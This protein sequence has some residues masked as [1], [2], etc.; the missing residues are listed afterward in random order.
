MHH[1]V[2]I[3]DAEVIIIIAINQD[4]QAPIF[5]LCDVGLVGDF[6]EIIPPLMKA[7]QSYKSAAISKM[8]NI[9]NNFNVTGQGFSFAQKEGGEEC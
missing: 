4:P 6:K 2:G 1:M 5:E 9:E 8:I 3:K 7:I